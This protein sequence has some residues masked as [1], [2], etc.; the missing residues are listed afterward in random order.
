MKT[1][2][3]CA[4]AFGILTS[5]VAALPQPDTTVIILDGAQ[6]HLANEHLQAPAETAFLPNLQV[7]IGSKFSP[8]MLQKV[9]N[10]LNE[11]TR[12]KMPPWSLYL[13]INCFSAC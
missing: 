3:L 12:R 13:R 10:E 6:S 2:I 5:S 8:N 4:A 11:K 7:P 1:F 9:L